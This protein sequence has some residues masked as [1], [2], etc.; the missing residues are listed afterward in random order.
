MIFKKNAI[1]VLLLL[2]F[3]LSCKKA[4]DISPIPSISYYSMNVVDATSL[5]SKHLEIKIDFID[6]DGNISFY[7]EDTIKNI[8]Y[9]LYQ[10]ENDTFRLVNLVYPYHFQIPYYEPLGIDKVLQGKIKTKFFLDDL[11]LYDTI[12]F[13]CYIF[14][15]DYNES[16]IISTPIILVDTL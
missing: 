15:R 6:G 4:E 3:L 5:E 1:V 7:E 13:E 16:N 8:I 12:K 9:T 10:M 14:D 11:Q 2:I